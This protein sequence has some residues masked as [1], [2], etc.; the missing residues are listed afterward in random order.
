M[1]C[2]YMTLKCNLMCMMVSVLINIEGF[3]GVM[4]VGEPEATRQGR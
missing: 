3:E 4:R 2:N 1:Y